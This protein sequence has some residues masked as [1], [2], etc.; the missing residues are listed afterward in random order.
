MKIK[1]SIKNLKINTAFIIG[2]I[3][4][5]VA[6][7]ARIFQAF[8]GLVDFETGFF[9]EDHFTTYIL[10]GALAVASV[11]ILAVSFL[12]GEIPQEKM[13]GRKS[14]VVALFAGIFGITLATSAVE[15]FS[16]FSVA[17]SSF[18]PM[19]EEQTLMSYLM[20]S[21]ALPK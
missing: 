15:Q 8:S 14:L 11:G 9:T 20:K 13:P 16:N 21:G 4:A 10:Y 18:N 12:A 5:V 1:G 17:Y 2:A 6:L 3:A 7:G 19:I